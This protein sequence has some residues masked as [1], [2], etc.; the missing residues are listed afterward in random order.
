MNYYYYITHYSVFE[1]FEFYYILFV[2][3][4]PYIDTKRKA[5]GLELNRFLMALADRTI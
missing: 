1:A 2:N 4:S 5:F 3:I